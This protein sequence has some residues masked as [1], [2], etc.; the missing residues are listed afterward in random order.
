MNPAVTVSNADGVAVIRIDNPP[1]N[2]LSQDVIEGLSAAIDA[3]AGDTSV[4]AV[5]VIGAGR[6]FVAG[7]DI[8]GLEHLAWGGG[9]GAP[10]IHDLLERIEDLPK[11]VVMAMHGTAL[12]GGLELAMA[13]HYR[14]AVPDSLMGQPEVN[15]GIIPGYGGTQR[16]PRLIGFERAVDLL[17]SGRAVSAAEASSWGW[18]HGQ[19]TADPIATAKEL[20]SGAGA[21]SL[22]PVDPSPMQ[23]PEALPAV[24]IGH[25][26]LAIDSILVDVLRR[27]LTKPLEDGLLVEADGFSRC[28]ATVDMDIGMKNFIQNGPRVPA[29]FLHE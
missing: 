15:L 29:A 6:T 3:V 27:G 5:V 24:N 2:A 26:S 17:R 19:P 1:V 9:S 12:G 16:L 4:R 23:I 7:A 14:V 22:R 21:K 10:E 20:L 28:K 25:R 13:G 8:K 11:P 18:A